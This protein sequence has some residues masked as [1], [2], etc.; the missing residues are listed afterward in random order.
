VTRGAGGLGAE[1]RRVGLLDPAWAGDTRRRQ[2]Q[3]PPQ[4]GRVAGFWRQPGRAGLGAGPRPRWPATATGSPARRPGAAR[5]PC[6][7]RPGLRQGRRGGQPD[8]YRRTATDAG[9]SPGAGPDSRCTP[10]RSRRWP[11]TSASPPSPAG[12]PAIRQH[13]LEMP[14]PVVAGAPRLPPGHH[15]QT[16]GP[17]WRNLEPVRPRGTTC[18][19]HRAGPHGELTAVDYASS[20]ARGPCLAKSPGAGIGVAEGMLTGERPAASRRR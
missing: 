19:H 8:L 9:C 18:G 17:S 7:R 15:R 3:R 4:P 5:R 16:R 2:L 10:I 1:G 14:A 12:P 11:V 13:V 20:P 6:A